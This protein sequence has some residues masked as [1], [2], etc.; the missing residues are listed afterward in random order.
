MNQQNLNDHKIERY[1]HNK[2]TITEQQA[3]EA[4]LNF[5]PQL[6][7]EVMELKELVELY[8]EKLFELK[9]RLNQVEDGLTAD[10]FFDEGGEG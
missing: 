8:D 2:M 1:V 6:K 4:E 10:N 5:N 3:F 9:K 7:K